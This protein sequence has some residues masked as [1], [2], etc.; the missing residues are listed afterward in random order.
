MKKRTFLKLTGLAGAGWVVSPFLGCNEPTEN[1]VDVAD[2]AAFK[3]HVQTPL[4]YGMDALAPA[5]DEETMGLHYGKHHAGYVRKLNA[6]LESDASRRSL[7]L[8]AL[9]A[10]LGDED[11]ALRNNGGG[12]YNHELYW[13][14]LR[15]GGANSPQGQLGQA[16]KERFGSFEVFQEVFAV[17]GSKRFG[18]GW[19]W[20]ILDTQ[21]QLQVTTTANQDNPLMERIVSQPGSPLLGMDVWEHAYYLNYQNRRADYISAFLDLVNWDFVAAQYASHFA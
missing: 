3:P 11:V 13:K 19:A 8:E 17:A 4:G 21:G 20:L 9:L 7:P 2:N 1:E 6:A 5:I 15:P 16:I 12:H 10:T 18:S 14:V